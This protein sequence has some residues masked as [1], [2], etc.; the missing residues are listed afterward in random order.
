[1]TQLYGLVVKAQSG[2]FTVETES[3]HIICKIPKRLRYQQR[4]KQQTQEERETT[5]VTVG[6]RVWLSLNKDGSG[7]VERVEP[8]HHVLSRAR[9]SANSRQL[10]HDREQ[11]LVA[12]PDQVIFVFAAKDPEPSLRKLDR[13]LVI[14]E[15]NDL[16]TIICINKIDL[17][18]EQSVI[19]Q[20]DLYRQ[21]GYPLILT[22]AMQNIGIEA[23]QTLLKDKI[24]VFSGSSGVGKSSLLNAVQAD[25]GVAVS[26]VSEATTK[27]MHT[28]RHTALYKLDFGG[29]VADTP[30]IRGVA[31]FN[32]E[33]DELDAYFREI[34]PLVEDCQFSDCKHKHEPG[35]AVQ[36][37]LKDGAISAERFESYRR[38]REEHEQLRRN[39][40]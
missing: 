39:E 36:Q 20:F 33:P 27:G 22:S 15:M 21:L 29:Y 6:D 26:A 2:F 7:T 30:G 9:P 11:V 1:M 4:K 13:L 28:T 25:L 40:Y 12:N 17:V 38:L 3:D 16:P 10:Q 24:S 32:V 19:K 23:L 14:T 5:I 34:A 31:L 35:C 8:R 18:D 37:A